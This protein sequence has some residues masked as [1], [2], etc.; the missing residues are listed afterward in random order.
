MQLNLARK[1]RS[2]NFDE[3]KGQPLVVRLVKNSLYRNLIFPVY[4]LSGTRG[5][6][7]T[8]LGRIFAAALNC[9]KLEEFQKDPQCK[10]PCLACSSC[11][12]MEDM[13]HPD[14]IEIDAAS[15]TGVDNVRQIIDAA[16]F[17][18]VLGTRKIYL[19]DE[20]HMLSKAAFNAFL[21]ILEEPPASVV[22]MLATTD[23]HKIL[24]TVSSRC[25]QLFFE[26]IKPQEVAQ[27]LA[28]ICAEESLAA[29]TD[30]LELIAREC[31]GSMRD[32][33]N[34]LERL[35]ALTSSGD[36]SHISAIMVRELLGSIDDEPVIELFKQ[37]VSG[38]ASAVLSSY[39]NLSIAQYNPFMVW[40]KLIEIIRRALWIKQG[41][42]PDDQAVSENF[43]SVIHSISYG[44]LIA[45]FEIGASYEQSFSKTSLP[46]TLLEMMLLKM[47]ASPLE[48]PV[49]PQKTIAKKAEP[50]V[51]PSV[52]PDAAKKEEKPVQVTP[53][54]QPKSTVPI[55]PGLPR[56]VECL[57]DLETVQ[58]PLVL[59]IFKQSIS[60]IFNEEGRSLEMYFPQDLLFF[61]DW[62]EN[63]SAVWQPRIEKFFGEGVLVIPHFTGVSTRERPLKIEPLAQKMKAQPEIEKKNLVKQP[64]AKI[65]KADPEKYEK[66][67]LVLS[68]FP[69]TLT[70]KEGS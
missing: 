18:P 23:H 70:V 25:F 44:H 27:H 47:A 40:K 9:Q 36:S 21:K 13:S 31:G 43:S 60:Q 49:T 48:S 55:E 11:R 30:A 54:V 68:V 28:F 63:T 46:S 26:S 51:E 4:L 5:C 24:E 50:K 10:I 62:L 14:F 45:L 20:A 29:D 16:S 17:V 22:F 35:R 57:K 41:V 42:A 38:D 69:G 37:I 34:F 19:I 65:V 56:W 32:A 6:G 1:W 7:K 33:L 15:H 52:R 66:G 8:S 12:A 64:T 39:Q 67:A 53:G 3:I 59:S 58:D 61:K 2:K